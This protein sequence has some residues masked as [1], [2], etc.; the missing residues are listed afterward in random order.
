VKKPN[1][2]SFN[3]WLSTFEHGERRYRE[4]DVGEHQPIQA[5]ATMSKRFPESMQHMR[6]KSSLF[7]AIAAADPQ[8]I[9]YLVCIERTE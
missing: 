5:R 6:F 8:N 3:E 4:C 9:R 1:S 7:T 2:G